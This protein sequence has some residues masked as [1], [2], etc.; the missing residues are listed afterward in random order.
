M[1]SARSALQPARV[2][3]QLAVK[4]SSPSKGDLAKGAT[5]TALKK[6]K[7]KKK[8]RKKMSGCGY[9]SP[10]KKTPKRKLPTTSKGMV[11][12]SA[13]QRMKHAFADAGDLVAARLRAAGALRVLHE[14]AT[15]EPT[16]D[17]KIQVKLFH[18]SKTKQPMVRT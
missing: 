6:K 9:A 12:A 5:K 18:H 11:S 1:L 4:L 14:V 3:L 8:K 16:A 2:V 15:K 13:N 7:K 17:N 10:A